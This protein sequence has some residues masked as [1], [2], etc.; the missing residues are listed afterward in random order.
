M[1]RILRD[2]FRSDELY[3]HLTDVIAVDDK[4]PVEELA[5]ELIIHEA[6]YVLAK[7]TDAAQGFFHHA[8]LQGEEGPELQRVARAN[9]KALRAFL[10][11]YRD[12]PKTE[13]KVI[14]EELA[15]F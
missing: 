3:L 9:V 7:Y 15:L 2:A 11:K 6:A 13:K 5:D 4:R 14:S 8:E 1:R 10:A 12:K